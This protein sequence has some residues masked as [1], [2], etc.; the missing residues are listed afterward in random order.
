MA[1]AKESRADFRTELTARIIDLIENGKA[2]WQ[3]PWRAG[4]AMGQFPMNAAT[5]RQYRGGNLF[6]LMA[7]QDQLGSDDPRWMTLNQANAAGYKIAKGAKSTTVEYWQFTKEETQNTPEGPKKVTVE[8]DRP[9][10]FYARVFNAVQ[11]EGI[12]PRAVAPKREAGWEPAEAA[13]RALVGSGARIFHD[14]SDSAYYRPSTDSIHLPSKE[15]FKEALDYYEVALHELGHWTGH[16]SRL[17]RDLTGRFGSPEYAKEELRAQMASLFLAAELGV[18]FN[19]DRHAA[20]NKSWLSALKEDKNLFF[21]A[22]RDAENIADYVIDLAIERERTPEQ[23]VPGFDAPAAPESRIFHRTDR[24]TLAEGVTTDPV[25]RSAIAE[26]A[27][28]AQA[29]ESTVPAFSAASAVDVARADGAYLGSLVGIATTTDGRAFAIQHVGSDQLV[30]HP[31]TPGLSEHVGSPD[32]PRVGAIRSAEQVVAVRYADKA[33]TVGTLSDADRLKVPHELTRDATRYPGLHGVS[34]THSLAQVAPSAF[35]GLE[36]F[37]GSRT[38]HPG[39][40]GSTPWHKGPA[41]MKLLSA[42]DNGVYEGPYLGTYTSPAWAP[43]PGRVFHVQ[44]AGPGVAILHPESERFASIQRGATIGVA[45][46][47]TDIRAL[48]GI[49]AERQQD[50]Q[51]VWS[52]GTFLAPGDPLVTTPKGVTLSAEVKARIFELGGIS[53]KVYAA[54]ETAKGSKYVGELVAIDDAT[55]IQQL[56]PGSYIAHDRKALERSLG[57]AVQGE[58]VEVSYTAGRIVAVSAPAQGKGQSMGVP[59]DAVDALAKQ[60]GLTA[61]TVIPVDQ[62]KGWEAGRFLGRVVAS[63]KGIVL[64]Q[65]SASKV[66]AHRVPGALP[67]EPFLSITYR[68]GTPHVEPGVARSRGPDRAR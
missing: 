55:V 58:R 39:L 62:V 40:A 41:S 32:A 57:E 13:E 2:P 65:V 16:A 8:L 45:Y 5:G 53:A 3:K 4:E 1:D 34:A 47:G 19:P 11:I 17:N 20:Y 26:L 6:W 67:A 51:A 42:R 33:P 64:Q 10:V 48:I 14:Q 61:S 9:R 37:D 18:P 29:D 36:D 22:A 31:W 38:M 52:R 7:R 24:G 23:R 63:D 28:T 12:P 59:R 43:E 21:Q 25:F 54:K 30:A 49:S 15:S 44:E 66:I 27:R 50:L 60:A 35:L 68:A 46:L 56:K